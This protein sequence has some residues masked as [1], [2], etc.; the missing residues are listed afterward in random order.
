MTVLTTSYLLLFVLAILAL[1]FYAQYLH[2][3]LEKDL[4]RYVS[5]LVIIPAG[6]THPLTKHTPSEVELSTELYK[7]LYAKKIPF[8]LE[9]VV[10]NMGEEIHFY[11]AAPRRHVKATTQII[12]AIWP[13][14]HITR[15]EEYDLLL[16]VPVNKNTIALGH[17]AQLRP[18]A[19]P[20]K[21]S[22]MVAHEPFLAVLQELSKLSTLGEGV[23]IQWLVKPASHKIAKNIAGNIESLQKGL[24]QYKDTH[25][26]FLLTPESIKNLSEKVNSPLFTVNA[27]IVAG[28]HTESGALTILKRLGKT[29]RDH[30]K[31][32]QYNQLDVVIPKRQEELIDGFFNNRFIESHTMILNAEEIATL[33]HLPGP[34]TKIPKLKRR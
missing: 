22:K 27:R 21:K 30:T 7:R 25:E 10:H 11:V 15:A 18:Y 28:A 31:S 26:E 33:F 1:F 24:Y 23:A 29:F 8:T 12:E 2:K 13:T 17:L 5:L 32:N 16:D 6:L 14:S 3:I 4:K 19:I 9:V 20:I 34:L